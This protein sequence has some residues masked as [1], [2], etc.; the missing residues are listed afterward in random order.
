MSA[1]HLNE[2]HERLRH[3][4]TFFAFPRTYPGAKIWPFS[5]TAE[6]LPRSMDYQIKLLDALDAQGRIRILARERMGFASTLHN[7]GLLYAC[8]P[9]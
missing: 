9:R 8:E 4:A 7:D 2:K 6:T 5:P 3:N 1:W